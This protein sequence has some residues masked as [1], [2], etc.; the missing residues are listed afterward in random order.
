[1]IAQTV[2]TTDNDSSEEEYTDD[3]E[4]DD[5]ELYHFEVSGA[6]P[7]RRMILF[8]ANQFET[9]F[10]Q[11]QGKRR[12]HPIEF[13][14][15]LDRLRAMFWTYRLVNVD[16]DAAAYV[17][18]RPPIGSTFQPDGSYITPDGIHIPRRLRERIQVVK[19]RFHE[20][21]RI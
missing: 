7:A 13:D 20:L 15:M 4:P 11:I 3:D 2:A 1:M 10:P 19:G 21:H 14:N 12:L 8:I 5:L 16:Y 18:E 17:Q 9:V 6:G